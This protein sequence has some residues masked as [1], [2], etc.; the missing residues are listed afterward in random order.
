[1]TKHNSNNRKIS[2]ME[3]G[4]TRDWLIKAVAKKAGFTQ[5]DVDIILY[6]L[7]EVLAEIVAKRGVL[8]LRG[9]FTMY[10]TERKPGR[11]Y[12]NNTKEFYVETKPSFYVSFKA[13]KQLLRFLPK[14]DEIVLEPIEEGDIQ[15]GEEEI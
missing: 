7:A 1:M 4:Y 9:L 3:P 5:G 10:L 2:L 11:A 8:H 6:T 15:D 14:A 12:N 13:S